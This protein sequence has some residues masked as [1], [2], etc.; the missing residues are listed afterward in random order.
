MNEIIK[1]IIKE[2]INQITIPINWDRYTEYKTEEGYVINLFGW[3]LNDENN[4]Y[5]REDFIIIRFIGSI[6]PLTFGYEYTTSSAR[7]CDKISEDLGISEETH[8]YCIKWEK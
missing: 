7:H 3:I 6:K 2:T 5:R 1:K 8:N 4:K